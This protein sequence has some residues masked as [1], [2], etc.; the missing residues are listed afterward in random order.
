MLLR[1]VDEPKGIFGRLG[2]GSHTGPAELIQ[3]V[4]VD[5]EEEAKRSML[6]VCY[7]DG[8]HTIRK[9]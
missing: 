5:L 1:L 6:C 7:E 8:W 4:L 3:L 2:Y 9:I